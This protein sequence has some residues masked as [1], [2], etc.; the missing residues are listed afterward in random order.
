MAQRLVIIFSLCFLLLTACGTAPQ[1]SEE[2]PVTYLYHTYE[3]CEVVDIDTHQWYASTHHYRVEIEVW[4]ENLG[5]T[6]YFEITGSGAFGKPIEADLQEG[7]KVM[8]RMTTI[9][10]ENGVVLGKWLNDYI[11][12]VL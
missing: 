8:M 3:E 2:R 7:D 12:E 10:D 4:C 1:S 5:D 6:H 11:E 9:V